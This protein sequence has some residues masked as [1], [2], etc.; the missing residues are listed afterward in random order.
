[1]KNR[2]DYEKL[3]Y[4][5]MLVAF[6]SIVQDWFMNDLLSVPFF[7][8]N[9]SAACCLL[10]LLRGSISSIAISNLHRL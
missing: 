9:F 5:M 10:L 1:M 7:N 8:I 2:P 4:P 6:A 3:S